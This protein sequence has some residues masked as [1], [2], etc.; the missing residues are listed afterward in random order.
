MAK[1]GRQRKFKSARALRKAVDAYWDSISYHVPAVVSTPTGEV[2]EKGNVRYVT[3]MLT[4]Q[5][6]GY[7]EPK[8]M[9][10]YLEPA[11]VPALL[12]Y[13]GISKSTWSAY[14]ADEKLGQVVAYWDARYEAYLVDRLETG[15][16]IA[17]VI[18]NLEHN[19]GWKHRQEIGMDRETRRAVSAS[20]MTMEEK[21]AVLKAAAMDFTGPEGGGTLG[22]DSS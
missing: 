18:F 2:D 10:K 5:A 9:V 16:H 22:A 3:K 12:L 14:R 19:F 20:G 4:E 6:G 8:T 1:I 17:G 11:S 13:L 7:G 21:L 15:K